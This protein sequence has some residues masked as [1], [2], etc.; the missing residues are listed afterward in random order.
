MK[1]I[2]LFQ[3]FCSD[4]IVFGNRRQATV[5][6]YERCI[7]TFLKRCPHVQELR[8]FN[9]ENIRSFFY[10]GRLNRGWKSKTMRGYHAAFSGFARWCVKRGFLKKDESPVARIEKPIAEKTLPKSV[11]KEQALLILDH[12]F[13]QQT[14]YRFLR[15]R[16]RAL[17]ATMI[18]AGLRVRE[19]LN[20]KLHDIDL[21]TGSLFVRCGKGAKDR[22]VPLC[23]KLRLYLEEYLK[24]RGRLRRNS[25]YLF[26]SRGKD[27]GM[28]YNSMKKVIEGVRARSGIQFTNHGLRHT[29]ATLM[30]EG[31]CDIYALSKMMGHSD[32]RTTTVYLSA[33]TAH[34]QEQI[35]KHPLNR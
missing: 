8:D 2:D 16:N 29:F 34:L 25:P 33:S 24:E 26:T 13:H 21:Q 35:Q 28:T 20:L 31:G 27:C 15:F 23:L 14:C 30:V 22:M 32:I 18:F 1:L 19:L 6:W 17:F 5:H 4:A 3:Q 11:T 7:G 9:E 10:D 12:A